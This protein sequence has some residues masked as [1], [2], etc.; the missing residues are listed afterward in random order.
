M[1]RL[2]LVA[3]L[4]FSTN[5]FL[6]PANSVFLQKK[7]SDENRKSESTFCAKSY[8]TFTHRWCADSII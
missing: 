7:L 5:K 3:F 8:G 6:I 2:S 4:S 1:V